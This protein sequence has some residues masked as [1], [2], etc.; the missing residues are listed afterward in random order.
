MSKNIIFERIFITMKEDL[1]ILYAQYI[2]DND[3]YDISPYEMLESATGCLC[4][5][6][7]PK[8]STIIDECIDLS[9]ENN[10]FDTDK[11]EE[12]SDL[13]MNKEKDNDISAA[14]SEF[15]TKSIIAK[16]VIDSLWYRGNFKLEDLALD[17]KWK[18]NCSPI[19]NM[20]A[21]YKSVMSATDYLDK[22]SL[23]LNKYEI[24][25]SDTCK[26]KAKVVVAKH[27]AETI[28]ESFEPDEYSISGTTIFKR[29][30]FL[31]NRRICPKTISGT[32][33]FCIIYI[34]FD[35]CSFKLGGS[36]LSRVTRKAAGGAPQINDADYFM[37]CYEIMREMVEDGIITAG[38]TIDRGGLYPAVKKLVGDDCGLTFSIRGIM[39]A[40]EEQDR[41]A[42]L[43]GE[44]PGVIIAIKEDDY[45]YFDAE[46]MLQD[47]IYFPLGQTN[48]DNH[49]SVIG[50]SECGIA[51][52]LQS[53][54][55][56]AS[57]AKSD[58]NF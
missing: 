2:I 14:F 44:T 51:D 13:L 10:N 43:F 11:I 56:S 9:P 7:I 19:G 5:K 24:K 6:Q 57:T 54:L 17:I 35:T 27:I 50:E 52:I 39:K 18:W 46:C 38:R 45:D 21:F 58:L 30:V 34:P 25:Q 29:K 55:T 4:E 36:M 23:P 20:A 41:V 37:D 49:V 3:R 47:I 1:S 48:S 28:K 16:S 8:T 26:I 32:D 31:N 22:L 40:Y 33:S 42:I 15:Q 53:L 12:Y